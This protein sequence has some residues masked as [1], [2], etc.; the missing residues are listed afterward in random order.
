MQNRFPLWKNLLV[1]IIFIIGI[2]YALPNLY[3]D[4]PS[5]QVSSAHAAKLMQEQAN[6]VESVIKAAGVAIKEFEFK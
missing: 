6:Q 3:G 4:D 5:V 2:V 1:L